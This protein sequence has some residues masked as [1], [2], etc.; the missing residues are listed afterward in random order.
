MRWIERNV[1]RFNE[2]VWPNYSWCHSEKTRVD[3]E[4]FLHCLRRGP[5]IQVPRGMNIVLQGF[6]NENCMSLR[7]SQAASWM[8]KGFLSTPW[9]PC[10]A[11]RV[12]F[13]W[14][15][16]ENQ[17][18]SGTWWVLEMCRHVAVPKKRKLQPRSQWPRSWPSHD[19]DHWI[20]LKGPNIATRIRPCQE[21]MVCFWVLRF[22]DSDCH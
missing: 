3:I 7:S 13:S 18:D 4:A 21:G 8:H 11:L 17:K 14:E 12:R 15:H 2:I 19:L 20:T 10:E 1:N 16:T 5:Q 9:K 22:W 6:G